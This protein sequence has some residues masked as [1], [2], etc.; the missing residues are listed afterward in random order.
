M[1]PFYHILSKTAPDLNKS[2][3]YDFLL[4]FL[5]PESPLVVQVGD[6]LG[7]QLD[8]VPHHLPVARQTRHRPD[9]QVKFK[10]E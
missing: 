4:V 5:L 3:T 2:T 9:P 1:K 10:I 7:G 6:D 8:V